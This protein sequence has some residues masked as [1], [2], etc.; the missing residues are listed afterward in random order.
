MPESLHIRIPDDQLAG[1]DRLAAE[2]HVYRS[3][4]V[5][6]A[7]AAVQVA[8]QQGL[9]ID[10]LAEHATIITG[11]SK[12]LAPVQ[13]NLDVATR[14]LK[15]IRD[16]VTDLSKTI[17]IER[18]ADRFMNEQI[19]RIAV[20]AAHAAITLASNRGF[21]DKEDVFKLLCDEADD[22]FREGVE[23]VEKGMKQ[24]RDDMAQTLA[25]GATS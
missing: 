13:R 20:R 10:R 22:S 6:D 25:L 7:I 17:A 3:T 4:W 12:D 11:L 9:S 19:L 21:D 1:I 15:D 14:A 24:A 2:R 18:A 5:R 16:V 8:H 23:F